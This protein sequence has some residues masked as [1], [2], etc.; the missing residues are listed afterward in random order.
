MSKL[1]VFSVFRYQILPTT[2][3]LQTRIDFNYSSIEDLIKDKNNVFRDVLLNPKTNYKGK[4]Y[5]VLARHEGSFEEH[6]F[7]RMGVKKN[8]VIRNK[9]FETT[10]ENDYPNALVYIDNNP[11]RQFLLIEHEPDAFTKPKTL[12]NI[13]EKTLNQY[14]YKYGL[15][16]YISKVTSISDFWDTMLYY[17][18]VIKTLRFDF[19]KPNMSNISAKA[20]EA[21]KILKNQSNSHKTILEMNA[22]KKGILENLTPENN[23]IKGLA[24]YCSDGGGIPTIIVKGSRKRIKTNKKEVTV[25]YDEIRFINQPLK[26]V[27]KFLENLLNDIDE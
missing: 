3:N 24:E 17:K 7:L 9:N 16:I 18:D 8:L 1:K 4:G 11:L 14:L 26:K 23:E 2:T 5:N 21:I 19:I 6:H 27:A 13:F 25:E 10:K 12:R 15:S 20:V 22:P